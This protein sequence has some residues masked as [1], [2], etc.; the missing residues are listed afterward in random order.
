MCSDVLGQSQDL[1]A[2]GEVY[3]T[4]LSKIPSEEFVLRFPQGHG[5]VGVHV[6]DS[7]VW[8]DCSY[9]P[10][11]DLAQGRVQWPRGWS[12]GLHRSKKN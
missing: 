1:I 3:A 9:G 6:A 8:S 11:G 10:G 12:M 2:I 4:R 7:C 5:P